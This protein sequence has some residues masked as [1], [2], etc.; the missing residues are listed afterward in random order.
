MSS[1]SIG[2]K[3]ATLDAIK[4]GLL[5]LD[6]IFESAQVGSSSNYVVVNSIPKSGTYLAMELI[7]TFGEH[8][9]IGYHCYTNGISKLN[10]DGSMDA[11]RPVPDALWTAAL[12]PGQFC[13]A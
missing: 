1:Y 5:H 7:K 4:S 9:D 8:I 13:A 3:V 11:I 6:A 12:K 2:D 10:S